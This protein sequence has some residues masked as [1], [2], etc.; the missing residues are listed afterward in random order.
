MSTQNS[1]HIN[2]LTFSTIGHKLLTCC[3]HNHGN[4]GYANLSLTLH[5][6]YCNT[7]VKATFLQSWRRGSMIPFNVQSYLSVNFLLL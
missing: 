4:V 5:D 3:I 1:S 6:H 7:T 2:S